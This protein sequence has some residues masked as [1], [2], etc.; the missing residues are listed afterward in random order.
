[1]KFII[2][3]IIVRHKIP[4]ILGLALITILIF[5][6][7]TGTLPVLDYGSV[8]KIQQQY[9]VVFL[10]RHGE[11]CDRSENQCLNDKR[12]ITVNGADDA[13]RQGEVFKKYF[14]HFSLYSTNT[15]RTIQTATYFAGTSPR[16]DEN[17]SVCNDSLIIEKINY[18]LTHS[19]N[20]P[21]VIFTHNHCLLYLAKK[22]RGKKIKVNYL[23][24]LVLHLEQG[25]LYLDGRFRS[26]WE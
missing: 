13:G 7:N 2:R 23:D 21:V 4:L 18:L 25:K 5:H 11:R 1:M 20:L 15:V 19:E 3:N 9:P 24:G 10:F 12:G 8:L 14:N 26:A 6:K 16:V 22:M 17:I